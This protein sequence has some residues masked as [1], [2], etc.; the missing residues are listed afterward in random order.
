VKELS[1]LLVAMSACCQFAR[2][3]VDVPATGTQQVLIARKELTDKL[4]SLATIPSIAPAENDCLKLIVAAEELETLERLV[5]ELGDIATG[6]AT[7]VETTVTGEGLKECWAN[8]PSSV[9]VTPRDHNSKVVKVFWSV[10]FSK[11][12]SQHQAHYYSR[13]VIILLAKMN[14]LFYKKEFYNIFVVVQCTR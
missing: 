2:Q 11:L 5:G 14:S 8:Q 7:A 10:L 9:T 3:S 4:A 1:R 6:G 13:S 12:V